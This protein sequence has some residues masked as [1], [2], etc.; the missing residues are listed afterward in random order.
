[1][2]A[3]VAATEP[4]DASLYKDNLALAVGI[5]AEDIILN[6]AP[7]PPKPTVRVDLTVAGSAGSFDAAARQSWKAGLAARLS[8]VTAD[9]VSLAVLTS[10]RRLG[11]V[12]LGRAVLSSASAALVAS[13]TRAARARGLQ[14]SSFTVSSR[15]LLPDDS[16]A[17]AVRS[18][19]ESTP[20]S[21]LA[22][23]T[24]QPV[25]A[26]SSVPVVEQ[27]RYDA[28]PDGQVVASITVPPTQTASVLSTVNT[29]TLDPA[30]ASASL[31]VANIA[32]S[33]LSA[34]PIYLQLPDPP[35][36]SASPNPPPPPPPVAAPVAAS[37][38]AS[39]PATTEPDPVTSPPAPP[40][41]DGITTKPGDNTA[42]A[43]G[44]GSPIGA[45]AGGLV[46]VLVLL[47]AAWMY[48]RYR[49][50]QLEL[51]EASDFYPPNMSQQPVDVNTIAEEERRARRKSRETIV[52]VDACGKP[53]AMVNV[54]PNVVKPARPAGLPPRVQTLT[55][56]EFIE[57]IS[58][59]RTDGQTPPQVHPLPSGRSK[60]GMAIVRGASTL[61]SEQQAEWV[62][63][64]AHIQKKLSKGAS[65]YIEADDDMETPPRFPAGS[66]SSSELPGGG[67]GQ[68][69]PP[70]PS[71]AA[72][73]RLAAASPMLRVVHQEGSTPAGDS[74]RRRSSHGTDEGA[75]PS[76]H[77]SFGK[78]RVVRAVGQAIQRGLH[79][80][81]VP[82]RRGSSVTKMPVAAVEKRPSA[83]LAERAALKARYEVSE[84]IVHVCKEVRET[85]A[86]YI[87][88]LQTCL[89][90]YA[91]PAI[92]QKILTMQESQAI[93]SN[94]EELC[95]CAA[96]LYE[97]MVREGT[98]NVDVEGERIGVLA[99]AFIQ[100]TPFFKLYAL[101]CRNYE[102]ALGTLASVKKGNP[103]F[104]PF[105]MAQ[106]QDA[107][108]RGMTVESFL[109]KPV[110][111]LTKYPLFFK[112]L[113]KGVGHSHP[114]RPSLEKAD[115]L[116]RT[117]SMAVNQT[118]SDE[119]ARL[120]TVQM[121]SDLGSAWMAMIAP[122]RKMEH[123][124]EGTV[125][126]GVRVQPI[127][128]YLLTDM[129]ILC[130]VV[131]KKQV[132]W[133]LTPLSRLSTNRQA[134]RI[135]HICATVQEDAVEGAGVGI[136]Q[137]NLGMG[138]APAPAPA[139]QQ[140]EAPPPAGVPRSRLINLS[141]CNADDVVEESYW[142][143]LPYEAAT[144]QLDEKLTSFCEAAQKASDMADPME[145]EDVAALVEKF[146]DKRFGGRRGARGSVMGSRSSV[147]PARA[148]AM[149]RS[150]RE[151]AAV[152]D[153]RRSTGQNSSE[154]Y[155]SSDRHT[156]DSPA[157]NS[158]VTNFVM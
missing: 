119:V 43:G 33:T 139:A 17:Q 143:E 16:A 99:H 9:H 19:L 89:D 148:S 107:R 62:N 108:C 57:A 66:G 29:L 86:I 11:G 42:T 111:R 81:P 75:S 27:V 122:H 149:A 70:V 50:K 28:P 46:A 153:S 121:L 104:M 95:R 154:R 8:G 71:A 5:P 73:A 6:V 156:G 22:T 79:A 65:M 3:S 141:L 135:S 38:V 68:A 101:Y 103:A 94:L 60:E 54:K 157:R 64:R 56:A 115:E 1:M 90:V 120:K 39:A 45:I 24:G 83:V 49:R 82:R 134:Q 146:K 152:Q 7:S 58:G 40:P 138:A 88:D 51:K 131:R 147:R 36:P 136:E 85:E 140:V 102:N 91:R 25:Q 21:T 127:N 72:T 125:H 113:L 145:N 61:D 87:A 41:T 63:R 130:Q 116:V 4:F 23:D 109:I 84:H 2:A 77:L 10:R 44:G 128:G 67:R 78:S 100:V 155:T 76:R 96:V 47:P 55:E 80:V 14:M 93:F 144:Y 98:A 106:S 114:D 112:D 97:L 26:F 18:Q 92:E 32:V 142:V 151:S 137:V 117:V 37:P 129:L 59:R 34:G 150:R 20:T 35:P 133:I 48:R 123:E 15:I 124:F 105:L 31:G 110:Q 132:P 74:S 53:M 158:A 52:G 12:V 13:T 126:L 69:L 118:L 30:A